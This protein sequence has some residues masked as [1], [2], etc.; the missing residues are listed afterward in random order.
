MYGLDHG[1]RLIDPI[2]IKLNRSKFVV[3]FG[4]VLNIVSNG[5]PNFRTVSVE[6]TSVGTFKILLSG[7]L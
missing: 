7:T 1:F 6:I 5:T 2:K 3:L 4:L